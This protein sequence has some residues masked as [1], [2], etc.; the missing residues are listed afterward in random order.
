[1][2]TFRLLVVN[3]GSTSTKIAVF[4]NERPLFEETIRHTKQELDRFGKIAEQFAFR[5]D[6]ILRTLEASGF[7]PAGF[8]A[9]VGRGGMVRPVQSGVYEMNEAL[10]RDLI[11]PPM[12]EHASNL[13]GLLAEEI[14]S[15]A[16]ARAFIA[17]P[18]VVDELQ[19]VARVSGHPLFR[20]V[21]IFHALN[22]KATAR[23]YAESVGKPYEELNLIVA[24]M[25]GGISVGA[26]RKGR[27]VD[28]NN[29][30]DGEGPF[31]PERSGTLP[32]GQL[33]ELCF[34]GKYTLGEVRKII[35]GQGGVNAHLGL[36]DMRE[37]RERAAAGDSQCR[38]V[39]EAMAYQVGKNIGAM[40]AVLEG[41]VDAILLTGGIAYGKMTTDYI[42][43]MVGFIAPVVIY[44]GE[45][46]MSALALNG[47]GVLTGR[48]EPKTYE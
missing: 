20:R 8:D 7:L 29:T 39:V 48:I 43:T 38:L 44:P 22:Q 2:K 23:R 6:V 37:V 28:V 46:E 35:N 11:D 17:D 27:V 40:A 30:L 42:E 16:G 14:A 13:G 19:E 25:G 36:N 32:A 1:M 45:D 12:G 10:R 24:H 31:S 41:R 9:V 47:Y 18:T 5:R 34:S 3:P 26:H 33:A 21:S 4:E 15:G